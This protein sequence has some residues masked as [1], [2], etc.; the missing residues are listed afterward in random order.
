MDDRS[1]DILMITYNRTAYTRLSLPRLLETCDD[2][3]RVWVWHNGAHVPTLEVV[4]QNRPHPRLHQFHHCPENKKL[5]EPINWLLGNANGRF[6]ALVNDDCLVSEGWA[7]HLRQALADVDELGVVACWHFPLDD[8]LPSMARHKIRTFR[9]GHTLM[10]NPWVQGSGIL[11]KRS[12]VQA[13]G[14]VTEEGFSAYCLKIAQAGWVNGWY[15]P[16]IPI[17]HMDDPRSSHTQLRCDRDLEDGLPLSARMRGV[18]T[19]AQWDQQL[20][21]SARIV[22]QAPADPRCYFGW[23]KSIRSAYGR[24]LH[25]LGK[26]TVHWYT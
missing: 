19:L 24:W 13:M 2:S 4:E 5:L 25:L 16:L 26:D 17:D 11:M 10:V 8:F 20:R 12:C 23:R 22:Q 6:L 14:H 21:R 18:R 15:L 9:N 7:G 1:I 3:M